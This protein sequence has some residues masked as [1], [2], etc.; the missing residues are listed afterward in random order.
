[1]PNSRDK[2]I[3]WD[4]KGQGFA[5]INGK[6][7]HVA[8]VKQNGLFTLFFYLVVP[9]PFFVIAPPAIIVNSYSNGVTRAEIL[10]NQWLKD[11]SIS[12]V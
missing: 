5:D 4:D 7:Q 2:K 1:M 6:K 12:R 8:S 9:P 10:F 3:T 11:T